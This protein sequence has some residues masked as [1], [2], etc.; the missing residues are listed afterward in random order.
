MLIENKP[1]AITTNRAIGRIP[2]I[3]AFLKDHPRAMVGWGRKASG[4]RAVA[5]ARW[6]RRPFVLL[7]DGFLRSI[8][9]HDPPLSLILDD[10]G[11]YYDATTSS[12]IETAIAHGASQDEAI[13][14]RAIMT[15]WQESGLSKYNHA[16]DYTGDLPEHYVLVADQCHG[17]LSVTMGMADAAS[18][19]AM[20]EAALIEWP[21]H[22]VLVKV[23]PDVLTHRK[24]GWLSAQAWRHPRIHLIADGCHPV[25]LIRNASAVYC[26]TSLIGFEALL[27]GR[28]VRCFG[29]PFYAG[30]GLTQDALPPPDR[31]GAARIEDLAHAALVTCT[32]YV[33]PRGGTIWT[34]EDAL[35]HARSERENWLAS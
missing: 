5:A 21:D 9:R 7:E 29:M 23:H 31:R 10:R 25:R 28:P 2:H 27:H 11:C 8:Q 17:D 13:R 1:M 18:F 24:S 26:V 35:I 16:R 30:W 33:D 6:M 3:D 22:R 20:L 14:A 19:T 4:R 32:R 15:L 12:R 34:V